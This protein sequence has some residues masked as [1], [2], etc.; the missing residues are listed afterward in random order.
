MV[1]IWIRHRKFFPIW[2]INVQSSME[3]NEQALGSQFIQI[4][5]FVTFLEEL[6]LHILVQYRHENQ[7][8]N[9]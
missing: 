3:I 7:E 4:I 6:S 1:M 5:H 2:K 8:E 9:R